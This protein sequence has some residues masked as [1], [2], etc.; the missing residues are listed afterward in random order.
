[1]GGNVG[2][3]E[4]VG[5]LL[6]REWPR[7]V[8]AQV[9]RPE[10]DRPHSQREAENGR[11]ARFD[12]GA[13]KRQLP[14]VA[15]SAKSGSSTGPAL[16]VGIHAGP[17]GLPDVEQA[18]EQRVRGGP[19]RCLGGLRPFSRRGNF[20]VWPFVPVAFARADALRALR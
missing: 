13:R 15:G 4:R 14:A 20:A 5:V 12:P 9:E 10:A 18:A 8:A 11:H 16:M 6:V 7:P 17:V 3:H 19:T 2:H 1:L